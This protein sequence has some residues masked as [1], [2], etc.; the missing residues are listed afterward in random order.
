MRIEEDGGLLDLGAV[1]TSGGQYEVCLL[2]ATGKDREQYDRTEQALYISC[3]S[4][5]A[6]SMPFFDAVRTS[7]LVMADGHLG[8]GRF[9]SGNEWHVNEHGLPPP[10]PD[11]KKCTPVRQ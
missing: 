3:T 6:A 4:Q 1:F 8:Q 11:W 7:Y 10:T 5:Y 2:Q 9:Y